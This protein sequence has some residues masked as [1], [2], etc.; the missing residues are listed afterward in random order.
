MREA[1]SPWSAAHEHREPKT[2]L[3]ARWSEYAIVPG[4][5]FLVDDCRPNFASVTNAAETVVEELLDRYGERRF[6]YRD[7]QGEWA[8][9]LHTGIQFRG[10][11]PFDS[12][13]PAQQRT[14]T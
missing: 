14:S 5:V 2:R 11:A 7:S 9:L 6:V 8:E 4:I 13:I 12:D 1:F 10:F 3:R